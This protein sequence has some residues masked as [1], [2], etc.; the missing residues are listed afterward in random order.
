MGPKPRATVPGDEMGPEHPTHRAGQ[1]YGAPN[2]PTDPQAD[3][4]HPY[5]RWHLGQ[6]VVPRP[7]R[8]TLRNGVVQLGQGRPAWP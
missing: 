8:T 4:P 1:L 5:R 2:P 6:N 3:G 7:P